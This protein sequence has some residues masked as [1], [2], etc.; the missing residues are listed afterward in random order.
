MRYINQCWISE[1]FSVA[2]SGFRPICP[3]PAAYW[4]EKQNRKNGDA[5]SQW[6]LLLK[7]IEKPRWRSLKVT[8]FRLLGGPCSDPKHCCQWPRAYGLRLEMSTVP[9]I[10]GLVWVEPVPYLRLWWKNR[11]WVVESLR[12]SSVPCFYALQI[13][14]IFIDDCAKQFYI[15]STSARFIQLFKQTILQKE[16]PQLW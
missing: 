5:K 3:L 1:P 9:I 14:Q 11:H 8:L 10:T 2:C 15:T 7:L 13:L 6:N 4:L 12:T 16:L